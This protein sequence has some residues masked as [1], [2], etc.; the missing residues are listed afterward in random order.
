LA[1]KI[2]LHCG[3]FAEQI[4]AKNGS[5][6]DQWPADFFLSPTWI[7]TYVRH[8]PVTD[9]YAYVT[10]SDVPIAV[11]SKGFRS[12]RLK[13]NY[14]SI[15]LNVTSSDALR[16][17][18]IETNGSIGK[19]SAHLIRAFPDMLQALSKKTDWAELRIDAFLEVEAREIQKH[20]QDAGYICHVWS[21]HK[22]YKTDLNKVRSQHAGVFLNSCSANTRSQLRKA[23][24]KA[25]VAL[26]ELK[27]EQSA[28]VEQALN[29]LGELAKL[30]SIKWNKTSS[31]QEGFALPAFYA[32]QQ[33][34]VK[35]SFAKNQLQMLRLSAGERPLAY[36]YNF[37]YQKNCLFY[38]SGIDY[39]DTEEFKPGLLAHWYAIE[40]NLAEGNHTYD[41]LAGTNRYKESLS[42]DI[43]NR[44]CLVIRRPDIRF[45]LEDLVRSLRRRWAS[46]NG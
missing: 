32:Y 23:Q 42:S 4:L 34:L 5:N 39:A 28:N 43:N 37:I 20:V 40:K 44:V 24:R 45:K 33:D 9:R 35:T 22:T 16:S 11:L 41:F 25:S 1:E 8:W 17:A 6:M 13:K 18:T 27:I 31:D 12:S 2:D 21:E 3:V 29:W 46:N 30:H 26:G 36:L 19:D 7:S 10:A 38:M 15:G 14:L